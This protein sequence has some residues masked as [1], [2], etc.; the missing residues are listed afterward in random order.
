MMATLLL[1]LPHSFDPWETKRWFEKHVQE[2]EVKC[3]FVGYERVGLFR[4]RGFRY[5]IKSEVLP[6][7]VGEWLLLHMQF[8]KYAIFETPTV[9]LNHLVGTSGGNSSFRMKI[10]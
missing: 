9:G 1:V 3:Q 7:P 8:V 10:T 5:E 6:E 2:H 4:H